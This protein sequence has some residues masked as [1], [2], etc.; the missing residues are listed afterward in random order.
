M[1]SL[2]I[3]WR[4]QVLFDRSYISPRYFMVYY[5]FYVVFIIYNYNFQNYR[6]I[7][8]RAGVLF[9]LNSS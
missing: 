1:F 4:N 6:D 2:C 8:G 3:C 5:V 7:Y 9:G